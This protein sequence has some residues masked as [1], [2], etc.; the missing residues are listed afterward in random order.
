M[1]ERLEKEDVEDASTVDEDS[2]EL[3]VVH[4]RADEERVLA[5]SWNMTQMVTSVESDGHL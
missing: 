2:P 5:G 1:I 4:D 3:D